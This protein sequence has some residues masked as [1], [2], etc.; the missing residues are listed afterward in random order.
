MATW[1]SSDGVPSREIR[2]PITRDKLLRHAGEDPSV[3]ESGSVDRLFELVSLAL[4]M[5]GGVFGSS[6]RTENSSRGWSF[7]SPAAAGSGVPGTSDGAS[8]QRP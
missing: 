8:S 4:A 2:F 1:L 5:A 3:R 6:M 7:Y